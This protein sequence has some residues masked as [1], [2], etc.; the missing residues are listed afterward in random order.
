MTKARSAVLA[1]LEGSS[2]P[3]TAAGVSDSL[4]GLCDLATVYRALH[5]LEGSGAVESFALYCSEHGMERYYA[6]R[7]SAH[8]HWFHCESC[9]RFV[10]LGACTI[11][12]LVESLGRDRG[13]QVRHH[14]MYLTGLCTDCSR[15]S[16]TTTR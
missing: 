8:R 5:W 7:R 14:T 11:E 2:E 1:T 12:K 10:D 4:S 3:L 6:S 13:L 15:Q 16:S 9:H